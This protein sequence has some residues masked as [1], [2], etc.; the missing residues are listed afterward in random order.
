MAL[1]VNLLAAPSSVRLERSLARS[2]F[3]AWVG[4]GNDRKFRIAEEHSKVKEVLHEAEK[5]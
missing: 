5:L 1:G 4:L 3:R 2:C